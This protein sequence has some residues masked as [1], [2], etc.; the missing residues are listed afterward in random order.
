MDTLQIDL[1]AQMLHHFINCKFNL[2]GNWSKSNKIS[3]SRGDFAGQS[4]Q[5]CIKVVGKSYLKD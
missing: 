3:D 5:L 4:F 1:I 2:N